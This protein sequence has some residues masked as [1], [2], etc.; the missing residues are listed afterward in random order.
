MSFSRDLLSKFGVPKWEYVL[1]SVFYHSSALRLSNPVQTRLHYTLYSD[2]T[3]VSCLKCIYICRTKY[4]I[5][6]L[7]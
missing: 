3:Y 7:I 6:Y 1:M 5:N 2:R 4:E